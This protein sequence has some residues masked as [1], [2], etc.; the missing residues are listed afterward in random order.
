[1][2]VGLSLDIER[3]LPLMRR[4]W[5]ISLLGQRFSPT[6]PKPLKRKS[7]WILYIYDQSKPSAFGLKLVSL[8]D[9]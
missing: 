3:Q 5:A 1:M 4:I 8:V 6:G 2:N 7:K 9:L